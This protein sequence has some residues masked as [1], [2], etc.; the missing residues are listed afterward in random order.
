MAV[1]LE[2]LGAVITLGGLLSF[3]IVAHVAGQ[4]SNTRAAA[5]AFVLIGGS[6]ILICFLG[7]VVWAVGVVTP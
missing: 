3:L 4:V 2:L 5:V 7:I 6:W 1:N